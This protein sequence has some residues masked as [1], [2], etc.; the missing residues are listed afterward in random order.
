MHYAP[1]PGI[2]PEYPIAAI[3][4][5]TAPQATSPWVMPGEYTAVLSVSGKSYSQPLTIKMDPRVKTPNTDLAQQ[6]KLSQQMYN[7]LLTVVPASDQVDALRKQLPD[8][9]KASTNSELA[10]AINGLD[11]KLQALAGGVTRRPGPGSEPPNLGNTRTRLL[12]LLGFLQE[13]DEAPTA[14]MKEAADEVQKSVPTLIQRWQ[15][16]KSKD[17]A[18]LNQKLHA[19]GLVELKGD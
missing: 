16:I 17:V 2:K 10:T 13:S 18:D 3:P 14:Q 11:Q 8:L 9:K 5:S 6:F 4:H 19:A 15:E 7:D 12:A 1:I